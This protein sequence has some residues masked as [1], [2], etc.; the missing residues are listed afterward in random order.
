MA[1]GAGDEA[2]IGRVYQLSPQWLAVRPQRSERS[3][4]LGVG[5]SCPCGPKRTTRKK[6]AQEIIWL[7]AGRSLWAWRATLMPMME[8]S[9]I[10][11]LVLICGVSCAVFPRSQDEPVSGGDAATGSG[12]GAGAGAGTGTGGY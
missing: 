12:P 7:G 8:L 3:A 9:I 6:P 1:I 2:S 5:L 4:V 11:G 10:F